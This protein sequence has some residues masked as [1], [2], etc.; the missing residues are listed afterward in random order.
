MAARAE[1]QIGKATSSVSGRERVAFE[2]V[3]GE[4]GFVVSKGQ[5]R[6]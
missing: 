5:R 2:M 6:S 1:Q 4:E 3:D